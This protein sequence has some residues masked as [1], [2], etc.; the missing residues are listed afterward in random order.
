M[1]RRRGIP[2]RSRAPAGPA[3]P[4]P[5]LPE[6]ATAN[7]PPEPVTIEEAQAVLPKIEGTQVLALKQTSDSRQVHGTWCI[8][9]ESADGVAKLVAK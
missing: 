1:R 3:T 7:L 8:D 6:S 4:P 5:R 9:G 2:R